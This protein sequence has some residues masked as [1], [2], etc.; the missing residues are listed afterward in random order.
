[1]VK[2][3][4]L[5]WDQEQR[6]V[7]CNCLMYK[8]S[9][10]SSKYKKIIDERVYYAYGMLGHCRKCVSRK[11]ANKTWVNT[12]K[13]LPFTFDSK[14]C[15]WC[16][17]LKPND[18]FTIDKKGT[19]GRHHVCNSCRRL[20]KYNLT[21]DQFNTLINSQNNQCA[22]CFR[23]FTVSGITQACIDHDHSCCNKEGSCGKCV[24]GL[25]CFECNKALGCLKDDLVIT[26]NAVKYLEKF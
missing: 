1:M 11:R 6:C 14:T 3:V 20:V 7:A 21:V 2:P 15:R 19:N 5:D 13:A 24:R 9:S 12:Q 22:I 16:E 8:T 17:V 4:Y 23:D 25:L 26:R 10:S 18:F